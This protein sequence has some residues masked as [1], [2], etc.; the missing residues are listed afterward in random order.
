MGVAETSVGPGN[1]TSLNVTVASRT[2][3]MDEATPGTVL[4]SVIRKEK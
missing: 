4:H 3:S 1:T 2:T